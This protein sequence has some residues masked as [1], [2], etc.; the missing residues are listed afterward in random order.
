MKMNL[1]SQV[2]SENVL[3]SHRTS[4]FI[5]H[6]CGAVSISGVLE[7]IIGHIFAKL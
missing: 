1:A 3:L 4:F 7:S 6:I 5:S 2:A